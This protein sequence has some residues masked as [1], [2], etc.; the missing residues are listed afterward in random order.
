MKFGREVDLL[1]V[2]ALALLFGWI[3]I[4][5]REPIAL[6]VLGCERQ[7]VPDELTLASGVCV[8]TSPRERATVQIAGMTFCVGGVVTIL[9][10]LKNNRNK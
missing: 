7:S 3:L 8:D 6:A 1:L 10:G 2:G 4:A 9:A 5:Y